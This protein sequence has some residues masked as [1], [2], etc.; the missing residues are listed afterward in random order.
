MKEQDSDS[1]KVL[2]G[3]AAASR[4]HAEGRV[5]GTQVEETHGKDIHNSEEV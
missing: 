1:Y 2:G 5:R 4:L 3:T